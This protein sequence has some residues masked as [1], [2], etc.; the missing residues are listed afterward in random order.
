MTIAVGNARELIALRVALNEALTYDEIRLVNWAVI[1]KE[2]GPAIAR[3]W[4]GEE[5]ARWAV[6]DLSETTENAAGVIV[7]ALRDMGLMDPPRA[8]ATPQ[9]P[10]VAQVLAGIH[11]RHEPAANPGQWVAELRRRA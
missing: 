9:P 4:T 10:P 11:T 7:T 1:A 2:S 3:G 8:P 6:G 5:L